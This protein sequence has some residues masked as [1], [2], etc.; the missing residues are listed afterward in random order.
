MYRGLCQSRSLA[1]LLCLSRGLRYHASSYEVTFYDKLKDLEQANISEKRAIENDNFIQRDLFR[2]GKQPKQLEVLRME[3]RFGNRSKIKAM[4]AK[5]DIKASVTFRELFS[6]AIAKKMLLH[7]WQTAVQDMPIL[8]MS[9]HKPE[10]LM[11]AMLAEGKGTAKPAKLLQRLG[12]LVL[13]RNIG[14]RGIKSMLSGH[15]TDRTWQRL[16]KELEGLDMTT[17]MKYAAI[18]NVSNALAQFEPL[19]L[20][21]FQAGSSAGKAV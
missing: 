9:Q 13:V 11:L 21:P 3:V 4:L 7:Y 19:K 6:A 18:R 1:L 2:Q 17:S 10:D 16:K 5:L 14:M 12:A 8:A 15:C 20:A